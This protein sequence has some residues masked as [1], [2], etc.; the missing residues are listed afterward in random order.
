[1]NAELKKKNKQNVKTVMSAFRGNR[2]L[3]ESENQFETIHFTLCE[4]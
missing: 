1:M 2:K 3:D 4:D